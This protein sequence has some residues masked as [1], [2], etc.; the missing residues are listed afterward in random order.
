MTIETKFNEGY[1]VFFLNHD[2][3]LDTIVRGFKIER[4]LGLTTIIYL[5]NKEEEKPIISVK[6]PEE[7][8]F[9][10]KKELLNSL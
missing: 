5:C 2:K 10:S 8:C 6:V 3:V 1:T 4:S 9:I 7:K